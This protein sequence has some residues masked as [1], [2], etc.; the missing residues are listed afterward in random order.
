MLAACSPRY[1]VLPLGRV[2][3]TC[4]L[5]DCYQITA[6][7]TPPEPERSFGDY[8]PGRWAWVLED[9][10]PLPRPS[11]RIRGRLGLW[12]LPEGVIEL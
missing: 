11:E 1:E 10:R 3:C 2:V 8:A 12:D 6:D 5:A 7:N 9:I 4:R